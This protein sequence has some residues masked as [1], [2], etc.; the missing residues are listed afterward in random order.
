MPKKEG[1]KEQLRC[2][3]FRKQTPEIQIAPPP[4]EPLYAEAYLC[5]RDEH[6]SDY[7]RNTTT[8]D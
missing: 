3:S 7:D 5:E 2:L 1:K 4:L 8:W 6:T